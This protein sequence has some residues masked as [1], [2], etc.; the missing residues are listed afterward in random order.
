MTPTTN[1][2]AVRTVLARPSGASI[3]ELAA[4]LHGTSDLAVIAAVSEISNPHAGFKA[5]VPDLVIVQLDRDVEALRPALETLARSV[6]AVVL[7]SANPA[8]ASL[9]YDVG[10]VD[11]W[12]AGQ[13]RVVLARTVSRVRGRLQAARE[14]RIGRR[15]L[16]AVRRRQSHVS[17]HRLPLRSEGMMVMVDPC[18]IRRLEAVGNYVRVLHGDESVVIRHT[19][20][21]LAARLGDAFLRVHRSHVVPID[22][23]RAIRSWRNHREV[24][25][26]DGATVPLGRRYSALV[27]RRL[28]SAPPAGPH[29]LSSVESILGVLEP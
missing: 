18:A 16:D 27:E 9:A 29:L 22:R 5:L 25:L 24:V 11:F 7:R 20:E 1:P 26:T 19:L 15:V 3:A 14:A 8:D 13:E 10:A 23:I 28:S 17:S 12:I 6:P 2:A 4:V 21:A